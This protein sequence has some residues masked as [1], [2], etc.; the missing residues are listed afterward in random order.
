MGDH[1]QQHLLLYGTVQG[2]NLRYAI[3]T[4]ATRR[5]ICGFV[6]NNVDGC[7]EVL[8][9]GEDEELNDFISWILTN[10]GQSR[11][12]RAKKIDRLGEEKFDDFRILY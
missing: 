6:K 2:V 7:V 3:K 5:R 12:K 10:P 4:E 11:I 9:I 8:V 1:H